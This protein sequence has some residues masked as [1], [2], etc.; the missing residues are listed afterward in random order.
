MANINILIPII[1]LWEGGWA[2]HINDRG[3][4]TN[5]GV[6]L[7]AWKNCGYDKDGDGDIDAE[8][9]KLITKGD[10]VDLLHKHYWDK[11]RADCIE[12]QSLANILVDWVWASGIWGVRIPQRLLQVTQDGIVGPVTLAAL[13]RVDAESFFSVIKQE[14]IIFCENICLKDSSQKMFLKGWINRINDFKFMD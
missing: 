10:V 6:T 8:D 13:N 1:F 11:W 14:R 12:S 2:D 4:K 7:A 9:L 3:G 5:M